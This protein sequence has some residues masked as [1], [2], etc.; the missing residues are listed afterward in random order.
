[1][2][3]GLSEQRQL[4]PAKRPLPLAVRAA[5]TPRIRRAPN[6]FAG[7]IF[8]ECSATSEL[9]ALLMAHIPGHELL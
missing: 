2:K 7:D 4:H 6:Q 1:V 8:F 3:Q 9:A 5:M